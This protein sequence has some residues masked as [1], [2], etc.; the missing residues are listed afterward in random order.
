MANKGT[1]YTEEQI[2][3]NLKEVDG[4]N[5][6]FRAECLNRWLFADGQEAQTIIEQWRQQYNHYRPH[7][8]LGYIPPAAFAEK[9]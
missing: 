5:G 7:S 8:S 2:L 1:R 6:T 3:R 4:F 9:F